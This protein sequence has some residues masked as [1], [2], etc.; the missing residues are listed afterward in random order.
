MYARKQRLQLCVLCGLDSGSESGIGQGFFVHSITLIS[1]KGRSPTC[2]TTALLYTNKAPLHSPPFPSADWNTEPDADSFWFF[3]WR[4]K[5]SPGSLQY[6]CGGR[7]SFCSTAK[8]ATWFAALFKLWTSFVLKRI[9]VYKFTF[10]KEMV[11]FFL[12]LYTAYH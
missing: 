7:H 10:F 5:L 3:F 1:L 8:M 4:L 9:G 2:T 11:G 12:I 6:Y